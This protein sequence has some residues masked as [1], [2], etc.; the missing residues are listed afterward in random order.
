MYST[1]PHVDRRAKGTTL[2]DNRKSRAIALIGLPP[3]CSRRIRT[4]VSTTNIPISPPGKPGSCL[5]HRNEGS[6]LD[7]DHLANGVPFARRSTPSALRSRKRRDLA[8]THDSC[9]RSK[10]HSQER[11]ITRTTRWPPP[12]GYASPSSKAWMRTPSSSPASR[13]RASTT[14]K[15]SS[16]SVNQSSGK[17]SDAAAALTG[18]IPPKS[19]K[20]KSTA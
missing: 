10:E 20:E 19:R 14:S 5:N 9:P 11:S 6:L 3:A 17:L 2:R 15:T 4:T 18:W 1:A 12:D 8:H 16:M 7:A 13:A